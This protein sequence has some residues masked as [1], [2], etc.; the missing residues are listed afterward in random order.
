MI[1]ALTVSTVSVTCLLEGAMCAIT[2]FCTGKKP[3]KRLLK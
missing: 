3:N 1:M 2:L